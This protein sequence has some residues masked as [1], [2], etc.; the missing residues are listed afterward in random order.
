MTENAQMAEKELRV[1][2]KLRNDFTYYAPKCLKI[3]D[4]ET[5]QIMPFVM[6]RAQ[7]YIHAKLEEQKARLGFVRAVI[8]KGRQQG[9]STY[10]A[11][12]YFHQATLHSGVSVFIL[13]HISDSTNHLFGMAKRYY[14]NAP[15]PILPTIEKMN[16]RRLE[17]KSINS[18]YGVGTAGSAQIGRGTTIRYFHGSEVAYWEHSGD[19]AAGVLQAVPRAANT[20]I[21]LESTANGSGNWFHKM[22]M[23]GL[24]ADSAGDFITIFVPW[25]WQPEYYRE[26]PAGF[27]I[28]PEEEEIM[29]LYGL[30]LGQICWRRGMIADAFSGQEWRFRREYPNTI[31]EAFSAS[32]ERL[33]PV[34]QVIAARKSQIKDPNAYIVGGCDP[35]RKGDRTVRAIRRGR[36]LLKVF[37]HNNMDE[38]TCA[39]LIANDIDK[40]Q[41]SK[42]FVDVG[43]GYGTVDR[44]KEMGYGDVVM[45]VHFGAAALQD[46]IFINKRAEMAD[47]VREWFNDGNCSIPDDDEI[48]IDLGSIPPLKEIGS[49]HRQGLP[50]KQEIKDTLGRSPDIFDA[51]GLTFAYPIARNIRA[52]KVRR[53]ETDVSRRNSPLSTVQDFNRRG[54]G[55]GKSRTFNQNIKIR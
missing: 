15:A 52:N 46:D 33:I 18:S 19:I 55:S 37:K 13:A 14:E 5:G 40:Y 48:Q 36:E 31:E 54:G 47:A 26:P 1:L 24:N 20:E 23:E 30:N 6:N 3:Q 27:I 35:A 50:P 39:G 8:V 43:C 44:L 49:R 17:F 32:G 12:R 29:M 53:A 9:C 51:I 25:Y 11:G 28:T 21:I 16:E 22:A 34:D 45:G 41:C 7:Q 42:Y 10:T 2:R 38:M 4:K